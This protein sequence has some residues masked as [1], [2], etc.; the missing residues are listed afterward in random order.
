MIKIIFSGTY[1]TP[2]VILNY[3]GIQCIRYVLAKT[4]RTFRSVY[5]NFEQSEKSK[6]LKKYGY[7]VITDFLNQ[8]EYEKVLVELNNAKNL[9]KLEPIID[10]S[11]FVERSTF[12]SENSD[13]IPNIFNSICKSKVLS[14]VI[15]SV[16]LR[17]F[18]VGDVWLDTIKH[19]DVDGAKDSQKEVHTDNFYDT[20]KIWYFPDEV[21]SA[22][23]PLMFAPK[24]HRFSIRRI[25]FEYLMSVRYKSKEHLAWRVSPLARR[26]MCPNFISITVPAN[27]LVI[28]NT[29]GFHRR[30][31]A[32]ANATRRQIHIR[33]R[34]EPFSDIL[35]KD[36]IIVDQ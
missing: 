18:Q 30:G 26:A 34:S 20:H 31:D 17:R 2:S 36:G 4:I 25:F 16:E 12:N 27:S 35:S 22:N 28:A 9:G 32:S 33:F 14:Q 11:T 15:E 5:I 1:V 8:S 3:F 10:G 6:I 23:G 7:L 24:S 21:T 13:D 19:G 29:H